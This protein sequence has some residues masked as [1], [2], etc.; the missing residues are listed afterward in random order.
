MFINI[1][2]LCM[3][4]IERND[5]WMKIIFGVIPLWK[6][7]L[8]LSLFENYLWSYLSLKIIF[9]VIPLLKLSLELSFFENYLWSYLSLKIIFGVIPLWKLSLE[10]SLFDIW[11]D[12]A[13]RSCLYSYITIY[14][15][16]SFCRYVNFN[17]KPWVFFCLLSNLGIEVVYHTFWSSRI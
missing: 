13:F 3:P 9:G 10:L 12:L 6:L 7:S 2:Y 5:L 11:S 1:Y 4:F 15:N 8:E 16:Y 17:T 14:S